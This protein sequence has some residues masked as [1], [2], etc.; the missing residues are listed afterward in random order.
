MS[1]SPSIPRAATAQAITIRWSPK[2]WS[3]AARSGRPPRI[4]NP[5]SS[6]VTSAPSARRPSTMAARRSLSFTRSSEA[7]STLR[8]TGGESRDHGE[9]GKLVDER[10]DC[11]PRDPNPVKLPAADHHPSLRLAHAGSR[12]DLDVRAHVPKRVEKRGARRIE[13]HVLDDELGAREERRS[14]DEECGGGEIS[15]D[16]ASP[17]RKRCRA[18]DL[19]LAGP[20]DGGG[21]ES[22]ESELGMV[23]RGKRLLHPR[24]AVGVE[25][26]EQHGG[27]HLG[28][29]DGKLV[30]DRA[31]SPTSGD[32]HRKTALASL[33]GGAHSGQRNHDPVERA[34]REALV[35]DQAAFEGLAGEDASGHARGR[36]RVP[37]IEG[38]L[39][40]GETT[41]VRVLRSR[42]SL[43]SEQ[44]RSRAR[45]GSRGWTRNPAPGETLR[46]ANGRKQSRREAR[47]CARSTCR[48]AARNGRAAVPE[49]RIS[50]KEW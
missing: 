1:H 29:R 6:S 34:A 25:S 17:R 39:G 32:R 37:A 10:R 18:F 42:R 38:R 20:D 50:L 15:G 43:R 4:S 16:L 36:A 28:A 2:L 47:A 45:E 26:R 9:N 12:L 5:S 46:A 30:V 21:P 3:R 35:P 48:P 33:D 24:G 13:A 31:E 11:L 22:Q 27:L 8:D 41:E 49:A 23:S 7:P 14:A 44:S 19:D 40:R